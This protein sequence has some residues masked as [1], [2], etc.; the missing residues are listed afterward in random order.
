ML[1]QEEAIHL[2]VYVAS[3][4]LTLF[5]VV[6]CAMDID[7]DSAAPSRAS[8][9]Q[10]LTLK[11]LVSS[12]SFGHPMIL[13]AHVGLHSISNASNERAKICMRRVELPEL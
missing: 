1:V 10:N 7:I 13:V 5:E 9:S 3:S 2:M 12:L 4:M 8:L 11:E 6:K